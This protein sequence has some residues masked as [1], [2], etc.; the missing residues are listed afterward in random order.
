MGVLPLLRLFVCVY[1]FQ[2]PLCPYVVLG[3]T[4]KEADGIQLIEIDSTHKPQSGWNNARSRTGRRYG[5]KV[6]RELIWI[7]KSAYGPLLL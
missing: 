5:E 3:R 7:R 6:V 4:G 2:I 1:I